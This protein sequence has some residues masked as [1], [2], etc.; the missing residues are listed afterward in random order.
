MSPSAI[1]W[2]DETWNPVT[3]CTKVS[4]G[5]RH[6]YAETVARRFWPTQYPPTA[7][8]IALTKE[9]PV[10]GP[11]PRRFTDVLCHVSRLAQPLKWRK[12]RRVFVNSMSDL[13]HPDVHRDF[14]LRVWLTMAQAQQHTFQILTKRPE[15]MNVLVGDWLRPAMTL[16]DGPR[17]NAPLWPLPNVWLGVSVEDQAAADERIPLLLQTPAALRFVSCE[18]LLGP[19]NLQG[20]LKAAKRI[21]LSADVNGMLAN[22]SF[23]ALTGEDGRPLNRLEAEA[24]LRALAARGVKLIR[25]SDECVG[26]SDQAGCPGHPEP[27]LDWVIV[28]GESGPQAR[29]CQVAWVRSIVGQCQ[30]AGVRCFIKQLGTYPLVEPNRLRHWEW[31]NINRPEDRR[32][33]QDGDWWRIHLVSRKG[34]DPAEWPENLRV[35]EWPR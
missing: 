10:Y 20:R 3:G 19:V 27:K 6:C 24:E 16:A 13:F 22:R 21:H 35:R 29:P 4:E 33:T 5:C 9:G 25:S 28:G 11:G 1:E 12:P 26:F 34:G 8:T 30:A 17:L 31:R 14:V 23:D 15:R 32:F 7:R 2:T 18:P